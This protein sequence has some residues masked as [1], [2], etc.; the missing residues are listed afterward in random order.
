MWPRSNQW[1]RALLGKNFQL[2]NKGNWPPEREWEAAFL[3][4]GPLFH[5]RIGWA[6]PAH[7]KKLLVPIVSYF[8][9]NFQ[10]HEVSF[11]I[12]PDVFVLFIFSDHSIDPLSHT[13]YKSNMLKNVN[14]TI[15][16]LFRWKIDAV[17]AAELIAQERR[18]VSGRR[19]T[20]T[21]KVERIDDRK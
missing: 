14:F 18:R 11:W 2:Y 16:W 12:I 20:P 5:S 4:S 7:L 15:Q 6:F 10:F 13:H 9:L 17:R 1:E 21:R 3:I 8:F 19:L